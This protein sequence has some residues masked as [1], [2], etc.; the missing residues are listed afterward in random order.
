M[1]LF[2]LSALQITAAVVAQL[3]ARKRAYH[4]P[5]A[6]F[7]AWAAASDL[8][9][10]IVQKRLYEPEG[11]HARVIFGVDQLLFMS[12][13]LALLVAVAHRVDRRATGH[14]MGSTIAV[15][16]VLWFGYPWTSQDWTYQAVYAVSMVPA[17]F[18]LGV[19]L[20][21]DGVLLPGN[22]LLAAFV[23]LGSVIALMTPQ[24]VFTGWSMIWMAQ[25][26]VYGLA[27]VIQAAWL[28]ELRTQ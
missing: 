21:R 10:L 2:A 23:L 13:P 7:L 6:L 9:R 3:V 26:G 17:A 1:P 14:A 22:V 16:V 11:E 18:L 8:F 12:A 24:D 20:R 25:A 19:L 15:L 27:V 4:R 5:L 28:W